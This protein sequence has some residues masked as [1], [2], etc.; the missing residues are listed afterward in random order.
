MP[1]LIVMI[2]I[3][4]ALGLTAIV[5]VFQTLKSKGSKN[6][7]GKT[8]VKDRDSIL[9]EANKRLAANPKDTTALLSLADLS[10]NEGDYQKAMKSYSVLM[11]L[12]GLNSVMDE[13]EINLRYGLSCMQCKNFNEAYKSLMIART[14]KPNDFEVNAY[15][16]KLEYL[17]KNYEKAHF[18]LKISLASQSDH[19]ESQKYMGQSLYR[20]KRYREAVTF[21]K[22][23][24]IN[25]PDDKESLFALA[26]AY[27]EMGQHEMAIKIFTH[28]RPDPLWGP[29]AALYSGSINAK[30]K[31]LD[32]AIMDY[33]IGLKHR[34][35]K[36]ELRLELMYRLAETNNQ[37]GNMPA[38]LDY[39]NQIAS[40]NPGYKNVKELIGRYSELSS[41][42]NLQVYMRAPSSEFIGLC[43]RITVEI[44]PN[45]KIKV[46][47]VTVRQ[48]SYVDILVEVKARKWEDVVLFRFNRTEGQVG[49]LFVRD[50]YA[51]SKEMHAGRGFCLTPGNFTTGATAFVE[52]RLIDLVNKADLMK[53][54]QKVKNYN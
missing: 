28:L 20:M 52:A 47:D 15:L 36:T 18:Y 3:L 12:S 30:K 6:K 25:A 51:R 8:R 43:R 7:E 33:E 38:A 44:F 22:L 23:T 14:T 2:I 45:A 32:L 17:K 9:K 11:D 26:R 27:Y 1:P 48:D 35:I 46:N 49:E 21:L 5:I 19:G 41:N 54:L 4:A 29:S 42:Y 37:R 16:G 53:I 31:D 39:L 34:E 50:L 40:L 10:Y 13:S 24:M